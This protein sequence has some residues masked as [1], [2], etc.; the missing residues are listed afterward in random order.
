MAGGRM[1]GSSADNMGCVPGAVNPT[2]RPHPAPCP[3][4]RHNAYSPSLLDN[5]PALPACPS[6]ALI[7]TS[8]IDGDRVA[9]ASAR[10]PA[11][12]AEGKGGSCGSRGS[13]HQRGG[14]T[15]TPGPS[16]AGRRWG[17]INRPNAARPC[18]LGPRLVPASPQGPR[19]RQ[20][21][22]AGGAGCG[23]AAGPNP[24]SCWEV[25]SSERSTTT[26]PHYTS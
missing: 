21:W 9:P 20:L 3:P 11:G 12:R 5:Y 23:R 10:R 18:A 26:R 25:T 6:D 1:A 16:R 24:V 2:P 17:G 19:E 13:C 7:T 15:A 22:T 4:L 14:N 8:E